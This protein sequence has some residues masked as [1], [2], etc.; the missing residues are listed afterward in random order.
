M[1]FN[2][3]C[4]ALLLTAAIV[5][6]G[7]P[8][9]AASKSWETVKNERTDAKTVLKETEVEIKSASGVLIVSLNHSSQI[10]VFTILGR[11]VNSETLPAGTSQLQLPAH[12]IYIVKVG[13]ITCKVAV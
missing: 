1:I 5:V 10:K 9:T 8:L 3:I 12:G 4:K 13:D 7:A 6:T 11:L 2:R